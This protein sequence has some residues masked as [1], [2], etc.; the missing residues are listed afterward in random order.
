MTARRVMEH[1]FTKR[2]AALAGIGLAA[3]LLAFSAKQTQ[4]AITIV[5][6]AGD[7]SGTGDGDNST[8]ALIPSDAQVITLGDNQYQD[9]CL[10]GPEGFESNYANSWGVFLLRTRP[11]IGNH[12]AHDTACSV[13][14]NGYFDYFN[15]AGSGLCDYSCRA[16]RRGE[17]WYSYNLGD[18]HFIAL[19]SECNGTPYDFCDHAAQK[20]WLQ[21]DLAA[22]SHY[23]TLAYWHRPIVAPSANHTDDEGNFANGVGG[24]PNVWQMLY[25]GGVDLVLQGHDHLYARYAHYNRAGNDVDGTGI[26]H[27]IVGT[28]GIDTYAV[29]ETKPGQEFAVSV[30]GIIKL[31]L[32]SASYSWQF[33]DTSNT[34]LD[35][36]SDNCR[37]PDRDGDTWSD[38]AEQI[39]GT[40]PG[41]R[42]GVNA[43][44]PDMNSDGFV[45]MTDITQVANWFGRSVPPAPARVNVAPDPPDGFVDIG[46]LTRLT[47][48]F[49]L[50]CT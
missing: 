28:G 7:I 35:S 42:C 3:A 23:C 29:S 12:D 9:G 4:G 26:R 1:R 17:G 18:W 45:D 11:A 10:T 46:D 27:F 5:A 47:A 6:G 2:S 30:L 25:D 14:G 41:L 34:I 32:G 24:S 8:A 36:G 43:W 20:A 50:R 44:P 15:G 38:A 16:G 19:N 13:D 49:G 39:I 33:V 37:A 40:N 48:L 31:T 22:N 21:A